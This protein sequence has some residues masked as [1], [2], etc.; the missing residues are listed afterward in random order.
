MPGSHKLNVPVPEL[1]KVHKAHTD[2][3]KQV[4]TKAGDVV[5]FSEVREQHW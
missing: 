3:V 5:L 1:M 4:E 2:F